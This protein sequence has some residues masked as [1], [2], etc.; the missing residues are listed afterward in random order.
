MAIPDW[1]WGGTS[2]SDAS[3]LPSA[4]SLDPV[5]ETLSTLSH[6]HR[7]EI[8]LAL[9][10]ADA[11]V[12]Y[13]SLRAATS[14]DDKGQ[15]NYHLRRLRGRFVVGGDDGYA[16]TAAGRSALR[17]ILSDDHLRSEPSD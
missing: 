15:F 5:S 9:T 11:P 7:L 1:T 14:V 13:S 10:R 16:P 2:D 6:P 8:L 4:A 17:T 12:D 3:T